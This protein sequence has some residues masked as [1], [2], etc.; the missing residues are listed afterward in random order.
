MSL[1]S[2]HSV[3]PRRALWPVGLTM[4]LIVPMSL[5]ALGL[6]APAWAIAVAPLVLLFGVCTAIDHI[7]GRDH[8]NISLEVL[9]ELEGDPYYRRLLFIVTGLFALSII[10]ACGLAAS[11]LFGPG[12]LIVFGIGLGLIHAP[13]VLVGHELGHAKSKRDRRVAQIALGLIGYGHFSIEHNTG[14]H[15]HVATP[16]DP[17]S[18]R[19]G[20]SIYRFALREI[21]GVFLGALRAERARLARKGLPFWHWRNAIAQS[22]AVTA[23]MALGLTLAFGPVALGVYVLICASVWFTITMANY[24]AHYGIARRMIDG[25][26]EPCRP[27]HSWN[28]SFFFSNLLF[29]NLQRHSDHHTNAQKPFQT[30]ADVDG[31]PELPSGYPGVFA[32]MLVPPLWFAVI[33]PMLLKAVD[34]DESRLNTGRQP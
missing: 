15:V 23:A 1:I 6:G 5:L 17:A 24:T 8:R 4:P 16:R 27:E 28:S 3:D 14:H 2:T 13:L 33:H 20:E 18:A 26:R 34:G 19:Y 12:Q 21:P 10:L 9:M 30:L 22:W 31:A 11:G 25:K 7:F 29:F 32:L